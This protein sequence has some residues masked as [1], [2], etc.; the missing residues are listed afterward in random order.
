MVTDT[1]IQKMRQSKSNAMGPGHDK[2][3]V[4]RIQPN[5]SEFFGNS[6]L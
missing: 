2:F 1:D 4:Y 3:A 6:E 5:P